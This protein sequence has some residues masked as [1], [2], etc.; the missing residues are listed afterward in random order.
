LRSCTESIRVLLLADSHL[1]FDLPA[2]PRVKRRRRGWDFQANYERALGLG[3]RGEV[4]LVVHGGDLLH[5]PRVPRSL[6]F[7]AF[8]PLLQIAEAGVPVFLVPGNHERSRI[9]HESLTSHPNI[10]VFGSPGTIG[11]SIRGIQV[12][13]SGFAYHRDTIRERFPEVL[14][15]TGWEDAAADLR[16]LCIHQ[17]VEGATVGPSDFTF[18]YGSDVIRC[19]DLPERFAAVLSGHI[20]RQQALRRDLRGSYLPTPVLY[21]G[22]VERTAFAERGEEKGYMVLQLDPDPL[23]GRVSSLE[24]VPLPT[25]PMVLRDLKPPD[26]KGSS[27]RAL[28]LNEKIMSILGSVSRTSVVRIRVHG[29]VQEAVR[30]QFGAA[31]LRAV[32]PP[33]MNL[34]IFFMEDLRDDGGGRIRVG[35]RTPRKS[36]S[37]SPTSRRR[38]GSLPDQLELTLSRREGDRPAL[39]PKGSLRLPS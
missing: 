35:P 36:T 29:S 2:K 4:D 1:G 27:W 28:E 5:R 33:E 30:H 32:A 6:I 37:V 20:H 22:S 16:L 12:A 14:R 10:H 21:P 13:V 19:R 7:Q 15:S 24:S 39:V 34:E 17:A 31:R 9:P 26:P 11:V 23:G 25:R 38:R 3:H 18:R 8:R